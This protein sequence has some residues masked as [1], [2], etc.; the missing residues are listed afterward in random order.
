MTAAKGILFDLDGVLYNGEEAVEGAAE[1]VEWV[2]GRKIPHLFV[3]NTTSRPRTALAKKLARLGIQAE[4]SAI[5]TPPAATLA[6]LQARPRGK[7]AL[8][9]PEATRTELA[10]LDLCNDSAESGA[11]YVVVRDLG[12]AWGFATLNRAF[13]LLYDN[14]DAVLI[15]LGMTR[16]WRSSSGVAL[17]VAPFVVALEHAADLKAVV[18]GKPAK[19]FFK[20]AAAKLNLRPEE[21]WMIGD[22]VRSDVGGAQ[23]AGLRGALA[24]T[25]KFRPSDLEGEIRPDAVLASVAELP[26]RWDERS[27]A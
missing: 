11:D 17:D 6:W 23:A 7:T 16:Y 22:D 27:G 12:Q 18:L 14:P 13:R 9:V 2:R 1:A 21:L 20:A 25:G 15:A 26:G 19:P 8:F 3:T 4:A 10:S 5:W 24:R